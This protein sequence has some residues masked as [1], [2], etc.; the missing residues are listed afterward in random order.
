MTEDES[1]MLR[2]AHDAILKLAA[3]HKQC[4]V[5]RV[6]NTNTIRGNGGEG[7]KARIG[8]AERNISALQTSAEKTQAWMR[9]QMAAVIAAV[10]AFLALVG[11][12]FMGGK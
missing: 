5:E 9:K 10:L 3:E 11:Q 1:Q 4:Q 7:L 6:A 2:E 12:H 8:V